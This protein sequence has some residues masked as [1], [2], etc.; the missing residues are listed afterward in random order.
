MQLTRRAFLWIALGGLIGTGV[1]PRIGTATAELRVW[2]L[3]LPAEPPTETRIEDFWQKYPD[4][5]IDPGQDS[6]AVLPGQD[7]L[8]KLLDRFVQTFR[9]SKQVLEENKIT[10][11]VRFISWHQNPFEVIQ[12][13]ARNEGEKGADVV[14]IGST[15]TAAL[16]Q[17]E[18]LADV[19]EVVQPIAHF[20]TTV[21]RRSCQIDGS[22]P[23]F[24]VPWTIDVRSWLYNKALLTDAG[25]EPEDILESWAALKR[26]CHILK[27]K[28]QQRQGFW[29]LAFPTAPQESST[30]HSATPWI[31]GGG[32][33]I[34]DASHHTDIDNERVVEALSFLADLAAQGC[35]PLPGRDGGPLWLADVE[36]G[37]LE[38]KYALAFLGPWIV[39]QMQ[40]GVSER[41]GN[42]GGLGN[43]SSTAASIFTG[44]THLALIRRSNRT[45]LEEQAGKALL[46][47]L[48]LGSLTGKPG[49]RTVPD[50]ISPRTD[51]LEKP[52][53][54]RNELV[55]PFSRV[56]LETNAGSYP[57]LPKW[58]EVEQVLARRLGN[59]WTRVG[60]IQGNATS[61]L[62][63]IVREELNRARGE[64]EVLVTPAG[65]PPHDRRSPGSLW[66]WLVKPR[67][68]LALAVVVVIG[69]ISLIRIWVHKSRSYRVPTEGE[70]PSE[71]ATG[72][73]SPV[74]AGELNSPA[75]QPPCLEDIL[76]ILARC[77]DSLHGAVVFDESGLDKATQESG[78]RKQIEEI[79]PQVQK[80]LQEIPRL[81]GIDTILEDPAHQAALASLLAGLSSVAV[82]HAR[83][84]AIEPSQT[85]S[86]EDVQRI[87]TYYTQSIAPLCEECRRVREAL[88]SSY[89]VELPC[90]LQVITAFPSHYLTV[91]ETGWT[92][93]K[94]L[95]ITEGDFRTCINNLLRNAV[96]ALA[97][98]SES[99]IRIWLALSGNTATLSIKD[100]GMG[101]H[102]EQ[103][104]QLLNNG[105]GLHDVEGCMA[106]WEG[107]FTIESPGVTQGAQVTLTFRVRS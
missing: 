44:G 57:S 63:G 33:K 38:E 27:E 74:L 79:K 99:E 31:W 21:A 52:I 69:V 7:W 25:L 50:P 24:A 36:K 66:Q 64:L 84:S 107:G 60:L 41:F 103:R 88:M 92:T 11:R 18:V 3:G 37:F 98:Q 26:G 72:Y 73:P 55:K 5:I 85:I 94:W 82:Y 15:W 14:Q 68:A 45:P 83:L 2:I 105:R 22:S 35:A 53:A 102:P 8:L 76:G 39:N 101:F 95:A 80:A 77:R 34:V 59:M 86:S 19:T 29:P 30:L 9:A 96:R 32:G 23:Y 78:W 1:A 58:A 49:D 62:Q 87:Q 4:L 91:D 48:A 81:Q 75:P 16:A 93:R 70:Q 90:A 89:Y 40:H 56:F 51:L 28:H 12:K 43:P 54:E 46:R 13:Q 47:F 104:N 106:R 67:L 97:D 71:Q 10:I 65:V 61:Q 20:F 17:E 42:Y 6:Q 100:N